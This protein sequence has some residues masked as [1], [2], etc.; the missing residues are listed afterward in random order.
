M[1]NVFTVLAVLLSL[2]VNAQQSN[3]KAWYEGPVTADHFRV[4]DGLPQNAE[5]FFK[6][7]ITMGENR[8][9]VKDGNM[10]II[11][12][13]G[14]V[15]TNR[16]ANFI[17]RDSLNDRLLEYAQLQFD[18]T[19]YFRR[20]IVNFMNN[21]PQLSSDDIW[22][23]VKFMESSMH[24]AVL[25]LEEA[26]DTGRDA[27]V[28]ADYRHEVDSL[29]QATVVTHRYSIPRQTESRLGLSCELGF[30]YSIMFGIDYMTGNSKYSLILADHGASD[31]Q[32]PATLFGYGYRILEN[33]S[34]ELYPFLNVG[35]NIHSTCY[36]AGMQARL[37][38]W[39]R[40]NVVSK[41]Y[42]DASAYCKV[43]FTHSDYRDLDA[44]NTINLAVGLDIATLISR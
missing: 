14:L 22:L 33:R 2:A 3:I 34:W 31:T 35:M 19:E 28:L 30:P 7:S 26:T 39:R 6:F 42:A 16:A 23:Q 21:S 1:R 38:Y 4:V 12:H 36:S 13:E 32:L 11:A 44:A 17:L 15:Y 20:K 29:L 41:R 25:D 5:R 37:M 9:V 43:Y 10:R 27:G 8:K 40:Y 24:E 18:I